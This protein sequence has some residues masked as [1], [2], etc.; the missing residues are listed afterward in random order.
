MAENWIIL[1]LRCTV[2]NGTGIYPGK[3][4]ITCPQCEGSG[5]ADSRL[6]AN[7]SDILDKLQELKTKI[8]QMQADI[9]SMSAQVDRIWNKV[10]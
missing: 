4:I 10:K 9:N 6:E 3:D 2:C 8:N 1:R 7:L 5:Y